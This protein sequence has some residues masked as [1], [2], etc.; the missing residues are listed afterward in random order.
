MLKNIVVRGARHHNLK[1]FDVSIPHN[2]ITVIT[3]VSGSGKTSL[4]FDTVYSEGQR[5]FVESLSSY[6]RQ[7]LELSAK[8]DADHI[9]GLSPSVAI[10]QRSLNASPRSIVGTTTEIYDYLRLLFARVGRVHCYSCGKEIQKTPAK[11]IVDSIMKMKGKRLYIEAPVVSSRKGS[12][13][14]HFETMLAE[15]FMRVKVD[16]EEY[17]LDDEIPE[18]H[19]NKKHNV[20][21][22]IDRIAVKESTDRKRVRASVEV[23]LEKGHGKVL[24]HEKDGRDI[25]LSE[26]FG[27]PD[28]NI[29]YDEI[30]PRSFSFNS[31]SGAC[32]VCHGLGFTMKMDENLIVRHPEKPPSR[33]AI[34]WLQSMVKEMVKTLIK[35]NGE[36]VKLPFSELSEK[37]RSELLY[38]TNY[39][40]DFSIKTRSM[41][42]KFRRPF[43]GVVNLFERRYRDTSSNIIRRELEKFL[44]RGTCSECGGMRLGKKALSVRIAGNNIHEIC[45]MSIEE[46]YKMFSS[47]DNFDFSDFKWKI[48]GKIIK[49]LSM[50]FKF[51]YKVGL[52]Y[53]TPNRKTATLSGG[54]SQRIHLATQIGSGLTGVT[55]VLDEPT[56]GLH[57]ADTASLI[58]ILTHLRDIGNNVIVVEHDRDIMDSADYII[59]LGPGPGLKGG[60]LV[61]SGDL[62]GLKSKE[63]SLTGKYLSGKSKIELPKKRRNPSDFIKIMGAFANNLKSCDVKIPLSVLTVVTGVS[64]SGKS[65]LVMETLYPA[66]MRKKSP[67]RKLLGK[68]KIKPKNVVEIDQ[69]PIGRTPR[70]NPATYT[71]IFD[72]I[73]SFFAELPEARA[74]GYKRGR[75]SFNV[76]G[77]RCEKCQGAGIIKIEMNL[78]PDTYVRCPEC[79]GK[80]FDAETLEI[81]YRGRNIYDVLE[82]EVSEALDLFDVFPAIKRKLCLLENIGLG[83]IKLGQ[84]A[85]TLSG[86]EAQRIK[87]SRELAK[88]RSS[89]A[90]Y[91]L[92]EPTTG[93]HFDDIRKLIHILNK[94]VDKG[95]TI[96]IIEHNPDIIKQADHI[97]DMG[98]LGGKNGGRIV[99]E[100]A[101]EDIAD[102]EKSLTAEHIR[103]Y[104]S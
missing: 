87:L 48:A 32:P 70:S 78:M 72:Y 25:L 30:E 52:G 80:R 102:S 63:D 24:V 103:P 67:C 96:V 83:Y 57:P 68:T 81:K 21:L 64:G 12:F 79:N 62:K 29:Y 39:E 6:A 18:L 95:A 90:F 66:L 94:L 69:S 47:A 50:R 97:I 98:P 73:R 65:S 1:G 37:T 74:R 54:E 45:E 36:D 23:A 88:Q 5:R 58:D 38:G 86:G 27:C 22:V 43:E 7:F 82:M 99:A 91:I 59:D 101:P 20:N 60:D 71:K 28:C 33:G 84:P 31:P 3:G 49:E 61:Y 92:D 40:L 41:R 55:Y 44:A 51:L 42:H 13:R 89:T 77:G 17:R 93:L 2:T 9:E 4:A 11:S 19:K 75:F 56:I 76:K 14:K 26:D 100:G 53:I 34:P 46:L 10:K 35:H 16:G 104:I 85:N 15:G 8:P